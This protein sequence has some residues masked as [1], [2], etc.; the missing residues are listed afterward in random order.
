MIDLHLI[1]SSYCASKA[2]TRAMTDCI[3][4]E[5]KATNN[6]HI[7]VCTVSP[8]F[9]DTGMFEG[10]YSNKYDMTSSMNHRFPGHRLKNLIFPPNS[11]EDIAK[12][13]VFAITHE[14]DEVT[15]PV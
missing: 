6:D 4:V 11:P 15:L 12:E 3:R 1:Y 7:R 2:A 10:S 8:Q 5:L 9:V 14:R 13:I